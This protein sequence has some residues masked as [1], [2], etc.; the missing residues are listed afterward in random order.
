[1]GEK[2]PVLYT[3]SFKKW[4]EIIDKAAGD[5]VDGMI[6]YVSRLKYRDFFRGRGYKSTCF[7]CLFFLYKLA[8][9]VKHSRSVE[10][11]YGCVFSSNTVVV[12]TPNSFSIVKVK[13]ENW[14]FTLF[15]DVISSD[16]GK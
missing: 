5:L 14:Y 1:E 11:M 7:C 10:R 16:I 2:P 12:P 13:N 3:A 15:S 4:Y 6:G 9:L 8:R